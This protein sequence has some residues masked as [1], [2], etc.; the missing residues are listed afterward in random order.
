[1]GPLSPSP[2]LSPTLALWCVRV[3]VRVCKIHWRGGMRRSGR[4]R[5]ALVECAEK[6][7]VREWMDVKP[8]TAANWEHPL[9]MAT[10]G[11]LALF[12]QVCGRG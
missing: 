10:R 1:M 8:R 12:I 9:E 2:F 4:L 5:E 6:S 11:R 7:A 3:R